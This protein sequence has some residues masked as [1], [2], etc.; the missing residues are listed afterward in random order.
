MQS[1]EI[2]RNTTIMTLCKHII[3]SGSDWAYLS[4]VWV[5]RSSHAAWLQTRNFERPPYTVEE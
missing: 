2:L 4:Q 5:A 1:R 3:V